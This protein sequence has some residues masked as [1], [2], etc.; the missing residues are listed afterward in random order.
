[1]FSLL[2][3]RVAAMDTATLLAA[4]TIAA[5]S[6]VALRERRDQI[7]DLLEQEAMAD[8]LTG[9][10]N[11]R[12]FEHALARSVAQARRDGSAVAL[13]TIDVDRFKAINDTWGHSVGDDALRLVGRS[14]SAVTR[15]AD[16]VARLGGDEFV[17][18]LDSGGTGAA[19]VVEALR[20][21]LDADTDLPCG[22]P[23]LSIGIAVLPADADTVDGLLAASDAA[24]YDAKAGGRNRA[25]YAGR[26]PAAAADAPSL[27]GRAAGPAAGRAGQ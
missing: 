1:M 16:V 20:A 6:I 14:L 24:L 9:L 7:L 27:V 4:L 15:E 21:R 22:P 12:S 17:A 23:T 8:A 3:A 25:A 26:P 2:P 19:R 18:V 10:A 5:L 11:R 13:L